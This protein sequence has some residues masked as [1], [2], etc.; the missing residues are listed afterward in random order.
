MQIDEVAE[1][2]GLCRTLHAPKHVFIASERVWQEIDG[3]VFF[4]GLQPK[5]RGDVIF[6]TEDADTTSP[7]HETLHSNFGF[8]E[9]L[10]KPLTRLIHGKYQLLKQFPQLTELL[11]R[12]LHY[13]EVHESSEFPAAHTEKFKGRV[14]HFVRVQ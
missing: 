6:L 9:L 4:R 1:I 11:K 7:I 14:R 5:S 8:E 2:L 13:Q 12:P 3:Q 10:T